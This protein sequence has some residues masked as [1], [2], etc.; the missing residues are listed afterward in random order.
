MLSILSTVSR[1]PVAYFNEFRVPEIQELFERL[2]F[3]KHPSDTPLREFYQIGGKRYKFVGNLTELTT[4]QFIDLDAQ[5][6]EPTAIVDNLHIICAI[7]LLPIIPKTPIQRLIEKMGLKKFR[8]LEHYL[9]TPLQETAENLYQNM[10]YALANSIGLFFCVLGQ[11]YTAIT[12]DCLRQE[13][14]NQLRL[15]S[16]KLSVSTTDSRLT[17]ALERIRGKL[18]LLQDGIGSYLWT[19]L[20]EVTPSNG[21]RSTI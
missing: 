8:S 12:K 15:A 14:T 3:L 2:D 6:K 17:N 5:T 11:I 20:P 19:E 18:D 4:G 21:N 10:P 7:F 1:K 13:M 16:M 9:E